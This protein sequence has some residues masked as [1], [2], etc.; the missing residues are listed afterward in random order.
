MAK[1][2]KPPR[3]TEIAGV[4]VGKPLVDPTAPTHLGGVHQGNA[5]GNSK[6]A[7]GL[8]H[9]DDHSATG[10]ARRS[11]GI[12]SGSREPILPIMPKISPP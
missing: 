12:D 2:Q 3:D 1:K 10:T 11:T 9:Q 6:H 5:K 7:A 4:R 8:E